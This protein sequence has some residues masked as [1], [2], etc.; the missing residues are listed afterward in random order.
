MHEGHRSGLAGEIER[1]VERGVATP[2]DDQALAMELRRRLHAIENLLVLE[3]L[4]A[5]HTQPGNVL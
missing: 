4:R 3:G 1:P 5:F 2:E